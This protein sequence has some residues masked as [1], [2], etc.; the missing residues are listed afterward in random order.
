[1]TSVAR[2]FG[3]ASFVFVVAAWPG[4][5]SAQP[6]ATV[7]L[8]TPDEALQHAL[9]S[10]LQ[11]WDIGVTTVEEPAPGASMPGAAERGRWLST[12]HHALAAVWISES[13]AGFALWIYDG[14]RGQV[15]ATPLASGP[16]FDDVMAA[17]VALTV[18]AMLR[19]G[20]VLGSRGPDRG[21]SEVVSRPLPQDAP[22]EPSVHEEPPDEAAAHGPASDVWAV[23][24][25]GGARGLA[26]APQQVEPRFFVAASWWP[27]ALEEVLGVAVA[28]F[29]GPGVEVQSG[30]LRGH[31]TDTSLVLG[32][33]VRGSVG[34]LDLGLVGWAGAH[35]TTLEGALPA[36]EQRV[37]RLDAGPLLG[38]DGEIGV[39]LDPRLRLGLLLGGTFPLMPT[40]YWVGR[41]VAMEVSPVNLRALLALEL[42]LTAP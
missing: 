14:A 12:R 15:V 3:T 19:R 20:P 40:T 31:W 23:T 33:Q 26:T 24:V 34:P 25:G 1:M 7:V 13:E 5:S 42:S 38:L 21:S 10:A 11:P 17:E 6:Q 36:I 30:G 41:D 22:T 2:M 9:S 16:P 4:V 29:S 32:L 28:A 35:L 18:K 8:A 27:A 37:S 39:R